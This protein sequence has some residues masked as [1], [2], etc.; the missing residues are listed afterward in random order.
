LATGIR[1]TASSFGRRPA[2]PG[3]E[4]LLAAIWIENVN[5]KGGM[6][7]GSVRKGG[8]LLVG[9]LRCYDCN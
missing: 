3:F 2:H 5:M 8:G 9:L 4:R 1:E 7:P 6:V